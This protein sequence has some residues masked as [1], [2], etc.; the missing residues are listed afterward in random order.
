MQS[1]YKESSAHDIEPFLSITL[2][3]LVCGTPRLFE[4]RIMDQVQAEDAFT[5]Y[6]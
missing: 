1:N 6:L 4:T 5:D 3:P 2:V